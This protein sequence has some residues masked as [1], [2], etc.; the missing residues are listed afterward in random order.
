MEHVQRAI[1]VVRTRRKELGIDDKSFVTAKIASGKVGVLEKNRTIVEKLARITDLE[2]VPFKDRDEGGRYADLPWQT[3]GA[4][5]VYVEFEKSI[6]GTAERERLT[7]E[8][9]KLEKGLASA[10]RQLGNE[11]FLA[12]APPNIVEGLKKQE[13]ENRQLLE[14]AKAALDALPLDVA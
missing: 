2:I 3:N 13:A 10:E 11:G 9:A 4:V 5:D 8:I 12:K 1:V 14:K 7:K 6:D